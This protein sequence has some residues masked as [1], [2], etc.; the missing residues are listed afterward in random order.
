[1]ALSVYW[2]NMLGDRNCSFWVV[3]GSPQGRLVENS[4]FVNGLKSCVR[5]STNTLG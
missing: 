3:L 2:D 1:M 4:E 5:K